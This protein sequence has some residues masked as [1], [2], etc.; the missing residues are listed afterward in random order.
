MRVH[1]LDALRA[2]ALLLG[3]SFHASMSFLLPPGLWAAGSTS[4]PAAL[5]FFVSYSHAFRMEVFFMLAGFFACLVVERRGLKAYLWD[6]FIR[7][8]LVFVV[9]LIPMNLLLTGL[10]IW[11]GR[12]TGWLQLPPEAASLPLWQLTIGALMQGSSLSLTHLWFL[13]YLSVVVIAFIGLAALFRMLPLGK[14][15]ATTRQ[16][17][18]A[19]R[20]LNTWWAPLLFAICVFPT[21]CMMDGYD[22]D[23]PD[24]GLV[25]RLPVF[26]LY[27]LCFGLGWLLHGRREAL[28]KFGARWSILLAASLVVG[29]FAWKVSTMQLMASLAKAPLGTHWRLLGAGLTSLTMAFAVTGWTGLFVRRVARP[30][31]WIRYLADSSYWVYLAH[32]P[33]VVYLKIVFARIAVPWWAKFLGIQIVAL[34]LL[35]LSYELLVRRTMIG[36][37]LNGRRRPTSGNLEGRL[38]GPMDEVRPSDAAAAVTVERFPSSGQ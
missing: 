3:V 13:Y 37:W 32:L 19:S 25:P 34:P 7:I 15:D 36:T 30:S 9:L 11:G 10:W 12:Q 33:L 17:D 24:K 4:P 28:E 31:A 6:R 26:T 21:L 22:V 23:T 1:G 35:L 27:F 20:L 29:V 2:F 14:R 18:W 16:G 5:G 38:S 8:F